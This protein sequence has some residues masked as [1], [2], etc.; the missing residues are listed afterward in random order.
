MILLENNI[1][2]DPV[3]LL[4]SKS[5][6][7][8]TNMFK[9]LKSLLT[10][11]VAGTA[12]GVLFSPEKGKKIRNKIKKEIDNGGLGLKTIKDTLGKMGEDIGETSKDVYEDVSETE[13][14]QNAEKTVK[15]QGGKAKKKLDKAIKKKV[16]SKTRKKAKKAIKKTKSVLEKV[17]NQILEGSED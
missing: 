10:G 11:I 16:S 15:E 13:A 14:Y 5:N 4:L 2:P 9:G 8:S 17:K 1:A 6:Y 3:S 12:L 7:N